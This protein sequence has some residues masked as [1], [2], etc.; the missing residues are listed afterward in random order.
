M[1][2]SFKCKDAL[3]LYEGKS[4][5]RF[6][7]FL[8]VA[9]RKLSQ[10]DA[11]QTLEFMK[12]PPGNHLEAMKGDRKGQHNVRINDQWRICFVWTSTGPVDVEIVDYH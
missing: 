9:E 5:R 1:I 10:L 4:P 12:A 8:A 11:A 3:A 6:K 7:E 2:Q